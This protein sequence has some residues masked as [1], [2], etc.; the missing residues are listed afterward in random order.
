[1][2]RKP[3]EIVSILQSK[4]GFVPSTR[5]ND[6]EWYELQLPDLPLIATK[7]SFNKKDIRDKLMARMARQ[8][9]VRKPYFD[10]MLDCTNGREAYYR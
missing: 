3:R 9:R 10:G 6:H 7:V 4:F 2:P 1:M 5:H 8:C